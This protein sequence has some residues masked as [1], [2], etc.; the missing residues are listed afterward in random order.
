MYL[1][2]VKVPAESKGRFDYFKR[3]ATIPGSQAFRPLD[4]GGCP[5]VKKN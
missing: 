3:L 5:L 4:A 2:Q 1:F